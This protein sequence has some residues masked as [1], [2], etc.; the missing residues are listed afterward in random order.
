MM[1][2]AVLFSLGTAMTTFT[3]CRETNKS[4]VE[5]AADDV[6]DEV[7]DAADDVSDALDDN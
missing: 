6:G 4:E 3:S 2:F 7:E 1:T 5:E